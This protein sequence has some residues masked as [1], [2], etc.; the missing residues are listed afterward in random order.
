[1]K[2]DRT[3]E[4]QWALS[5]VA[6]SKLL[7]WLDSDEQSAGE[8]YERLRQKL[9][10]FFEH[11][12]CPIPSELADK[13]LD[14]IARKLESGEIITIADPASYCYGVASKI[15]K[16]FWRNPDRDIVSLDYQPS[17]SDPSGAVVDKSA[18]LID[19]QE[20][21]LNLSHLD[22]CLGKL[23]PE[24]RELIIK[25]Y[26]GDHRDR[27]NNRQQLS[28]KLNIPS[29]SLRI[30]ALRIREQLYECIN[31]CNRRKDEK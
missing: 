5:E 26:E 20:K 24:D 28:S 4:K 9:L 7:R 30:R 3:T 1:M 2:K 21:E 22:F 16:E 14:R 13:T 19:E 18:A 6:F 10:L 29:G 11:R 25:Y 12:G 27:I 17:A 31:R 23:S 15:L 8:K